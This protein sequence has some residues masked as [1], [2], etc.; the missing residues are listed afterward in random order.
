MI[1]GYSCLWYYAVTINSEIFFLADLFDGSNYTIVNNSV[2]RK[3]HIKQD[4]DKLE[5][6]LQRKGNALENFDAQRKDED[7]AF[8]SFKIWVAFFNITYSKATLAIWR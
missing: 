6:Q 2:S 4:N 7:G 5:N 8:D 1:A 3:F